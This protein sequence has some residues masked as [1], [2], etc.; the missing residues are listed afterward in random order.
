MVGH[1]LDFEY[2]SPERR[3]ELEKDFNSSAVKPLVTNEIKN[4]KWN[5]DMYGVRSRLQVQRD[6]KL[7]NWQG[8]EDWKNDGAQVV[9][10]YTKEKD[11][12][13]GRTERF[14]D[15]V[16]MKANG[17]LI[18]QLSLVKPSRQV[19]AYSICKSL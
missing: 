18:S 8:T 17:Q 19:V 11:T 9:A 13:V 6:V 5:C 15:Q 3:Q 7:Y 2:I 12:L 10:E 16:K 4:K 14:E 1:A